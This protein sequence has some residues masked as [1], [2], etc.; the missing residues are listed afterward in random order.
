M[1][2][3]DLSEREIHLTICAHCGDERNPWLDDPSVGAVDDTMLPPAPPSI[4]LE[5]NP[6]LIDV[7]DSL[8]FLE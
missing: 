4:V 3:V 5:I 8:P 1:V 2:R 7:D 6:S